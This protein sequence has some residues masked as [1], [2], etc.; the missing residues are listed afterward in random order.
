MLNFVDRCSRAV[1]VAFSPT[2]EMQSI[3]GLV[4]HF[5]STVCRPL[6]IN[7]RV[8]F[9]D[10][11]TELKNDAMTALSVKYS[12]RQEFSATDTPAQN[13]LAERANRTICE[14]TRAMLFHSAAPVSLWSC[15]ATTAAY[16]VTRLP[17]VALSGGIPYSRWYGKPVESLSHLRV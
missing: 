12:F 11:G 8:L 4:E 13:G 14:M 6:G 16:L 3:V 10:N 2:K 9:S 7:V 1:H 15:A 17:C 5:I